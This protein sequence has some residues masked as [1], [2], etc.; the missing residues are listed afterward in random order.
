[1]AVI[2]LQAQTFLKKVFDLLSVCYSVKVVHAP[3]P[4]AL[5]EIMTVGGAKAQKKCITLIAALIFYVSFAYGIC[6]ETAFKCLSW[7][8]LTVTC[9]YMLLYIICI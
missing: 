2:Q 3:E 8:T 6:I 1:M 7:V 4:T 5:G 9:A